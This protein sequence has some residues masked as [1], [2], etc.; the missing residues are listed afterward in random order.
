M[1][2]DYDYSDED[3]DYSDEDEEMMDTQEDGQRAVSELLTPD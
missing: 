1:S 2:S 3:A